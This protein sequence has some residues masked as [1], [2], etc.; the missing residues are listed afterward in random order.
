M[1]RERKRERERERDENVSC[2]LVQK[3]AREEK[4]RMK[5][6]SARPAIIQIFS[7]F[8]VRLAFGCFCYRSRN[9]GR[10]RRFP[11]SECKRQRKGT[12]EE[13]QSTQ[14][15]VTSVRIYSQKCARS[16]IKCN[17]RNVLL[18]CQ[19]RVSEFVDPAQ[20]HLI[21]GIYCSGMGE[22]RI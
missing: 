19:N 7:I 3:Y 16:N 9:V 6:H 10:F 14:P 1:M 12:G 15:N 18:S 5:N 11:S 20:E 13:M 17:E 2:F 4:R 21:L 8:V 22:G